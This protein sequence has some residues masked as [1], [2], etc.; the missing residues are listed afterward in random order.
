MILHQ[1]MDKEAMAFLE[2]DKLLEKITPSS[3]YGKRLLKEPYVFFRGDEASLISHYNRLEAFECMGSKVEKDR[4][5]RCLSEIKNISHSLEKIENHQLPSV[6][7]FFE[8]KKFLFFFR[9]LSNSLKDESR[10][11]DLY[12]LDFQPSIWTILDPKNTNQ[13]YFSIDSDY[14]IE[15][16]KELDKYRELER[17]EISKICSKL[18][19]LYDLSLKNRTDFLL[20]RS[21]IRNHALRKSENCTVISENAFSVHYKVTKSAD[22]PDYS[23]EIE[24]IRDEMETEEIRYRKELMESLEP[25]LDYLR[26]QMVSI[27]EFDRDIALLAYK[28]EYDAC[29]PEIVDKRQNL[30]IEDG[31]HWDVKA[32]CEV[33][34][35]LYDPL[36]ITLE[37]GSTVIV[38]ANMGGKTTSLKTIGRLYTAC[39]LGLPITAKNF[40]SSLFDSVNCV[41]RTREEE[42][43]SG[44]A[45]EVRRILPVFGSGCHLNLIDEFGSATNPKEGDAL[46]SSVVSTLSEKES[47]TVFITHFSGAL[48]FGGQKYQTGFLK[49]YEDQILT[50]DNIYRYIDHRL[51]QITGHH[52]P[53]AAIEISKAFGLPDIVI[54][55]AKRLSDH[56]SE[57]NDSLKNKEEEV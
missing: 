2:I 5:K 26:R 16:R 8:I 42:G 25:Y 28:M 41:Y 18:H 32:F 17:A 49:E 3:H 7:D 38:G 48:S 40:T 36:T 9:R 44:F 56:S 30:K 50:A 20:E 10:I 13:F 4:I 22:D 11:K 15:L 52:I 53:Q 51:V 55:Q 46:A 45:M 1:L 6:V 12:G 19:K 57:A 39:A 37:K 27:G 43:L 24:R 23:M 33:K 47:I 31:V 54:E 21:D 29:F 14:A 34:G 35:F